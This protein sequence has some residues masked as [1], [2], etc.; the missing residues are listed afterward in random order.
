MCND[1]EQFDNL[2][3]LDIPERI[4]VGDG[5]YLTATM[6]GNVKLS[7]NIDGNIKSCTLREVLYVP[8]LS[9]NLLSVSKA[10]DAGMLV[11]FQ[12]DTC[13]IRNKKGKVILQASKHRGL[14]YVDTMEQENPSK[15]PESASK[16]REK[17]TQFANSTESDNDKISKE[18]MWHSRFGQLGEQSLTKLVKEDMVSGLDHKKS[19]TKEEI[20]FCEPCAEGKQQHTKFPRNDSTRANNNLDL[21]HTDVCGKMEKPSLSGK[22]YFISFID[23]KSRYVWTYPMRKKSEAFETFLKWKAKAERLRERKLKE[24]KI[25]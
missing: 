10:T 17:S 6:Q 4:K 16:E 22:E 2:T 1:K 13:E 25:G 3:M 15:I 7:L 21:V 5:F 19:F 24:I 18:R 12:G 20:G 23:D 11:L 9:Y 14:Y 8:E